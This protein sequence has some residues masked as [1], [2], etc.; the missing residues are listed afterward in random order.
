MAGD[1]LDFLFKLDEALAVTGAQFG[2][3]IRIDAYADEFQVG[4]HFDERDFNLFVEL[5]ELHFQ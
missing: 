3:A 4:E 2:K 1:F 5:G